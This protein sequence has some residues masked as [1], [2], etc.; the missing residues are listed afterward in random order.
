[1]VDD[2]TRDAVEAAST[3]A[4]KI[5]RVQLTED[6]FLGEV[7]GSRMFRV[8]AGWEIE[9]LK[10]ERSVTEVISVMQLR[11][12]M[13]DTAVQSI[14]IPSQSA[15]TMEAVKQVLQQSGQDKTLFWEA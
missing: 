11:A 9:Q 8:T 1:M 5:A 3:L 15:L 4:S 12:A 10:R 14:L 7:F 6:K 13:E 2:S